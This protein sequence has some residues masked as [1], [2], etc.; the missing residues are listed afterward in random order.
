MP[1]MPWACNSLF[2]VASSELGS[3]EASR[4]ATVVCGDLSDWDV[5]D[6]IDIGHVCSF[7]AGT[8]ALAACE[9]EPCQR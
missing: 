8:R 9:A 4:Q 7:C 6:V 5:P 1:T 3:E 2:G